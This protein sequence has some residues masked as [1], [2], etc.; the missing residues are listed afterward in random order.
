M[1]HDNVGLQKERLE[2]PDVGVLVKGRVYLDTMRDSHQTMRKTNDILE[3]AEQVFEDV[4]NDFSDTDCVRERFSAWRNQYGE[5]YTEAYIS[6]CLPKLV[7][8]FVRLRL[9]SWNPFQEQCKDIEEMRWFDSLLF[10]GF[11]EGETADKDNEDIKILPAI[12]STFPKPWFE[13][14]QEEKTI[15]QLENLCRFL[16]FASQLLD[17]ASLTSSDMQKREMREQQKQIRKLLV[18]I[19]A[20]DYTMK[21]SESGSLR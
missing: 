1:L 21:L 8:P 20:L 6:L 4:V 12:V 18:T 13:E 16:C 15:P 10:F 5:S 11:E 17:K 9:V 2:G 7:N 19:H 14:L 3:R